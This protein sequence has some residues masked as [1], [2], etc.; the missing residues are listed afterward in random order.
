M[1]SQP[2]AWPNPVKIRGVDGETSSIRLVQLDEPWQSPDDA[3][4]QYEVKVVTKRGV[5][6]LMGGQ[7]DIDAILQ[8]RNGLEELLQGDPVEPVIGDLDCR[9]LVGIY[10]RD[11]KIWITGTT[12]HRHCYIL[13][14]TRNFGSPDETFAFAI[15]PEELSSVIDQLSVMVRYIE[16]WKKRHRESWNSR[17]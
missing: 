7:T 4:L 10:R 6:W 5:E 2:P 13:N 17:H 11:G 9:L 16:H 1:Q 14:D 15:M 8:L 12:R 3:I